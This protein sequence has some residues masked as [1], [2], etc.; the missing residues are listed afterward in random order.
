MVYGESRLKGK[1]RGQDSKGRQLSARL[2]SVHPAKTCAQSY[3]QRD[4][5][6]SKEEDIY[7]PSWTKVGRS[8]LGWS[9]AFP[10]LCVAQ[11]TGLSV[12]VFLLQGMEYV[13]GSPGAKNGDSGWQDNLEGEGICYHS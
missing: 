13:P 12:T 4:P 11:N 9:Q 7:M 2:Q 10:G 8:Q 3:K 1:G 6:I 5:H